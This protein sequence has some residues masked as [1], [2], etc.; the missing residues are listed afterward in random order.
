MALKILCYGDINAI[1]TVRGL[2]DQLDAHFEE[3]HLIS[4]FCT[5]S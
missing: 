1:S 5:N 2:I 4:C 3:C